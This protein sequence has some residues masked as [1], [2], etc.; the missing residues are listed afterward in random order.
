MTL[1]I[2]W[3]MLHLS[4]AHTIVIMIAVS[5]SLNP[6][7]QI[8]MVATRATI[9]RYLIHGIRIPVSKIHVVR[10]HEARTPEARTHECISKTRA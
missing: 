10:T 5:G 7:V 4:G 3:T 9:D 8:G 2:V 6:A 1:T